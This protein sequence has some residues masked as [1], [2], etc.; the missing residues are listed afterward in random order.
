MSTVQQAVIERD[1]NARFLI[2]IISG[3][4]RADVFACLPRIVSLLKGTERER[5]TV[6]DV[7]MK[8]LTGTGGGSTGPTLPH[9]QPPGI[10]RRD[11][12][13]GPAAPMSGPQSQAQ[14][15]PGSSQARGPVMSPSEL[16]V[17]LH[18]MEDNVGWKAACEGKMECFSERNG[19]MF[20][21]RLLFVHCHSCPCFPL[22]FTTISHGHLLQPPRAL[23]V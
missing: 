7:F 15:Q 3:L 13:T 5:R 23:Q 1:L 14:G 11:S 12:S 19:P 16:L 21:P 4:E 22:A 6:T 20:F 17:E 18:A 2:P 10:T 8:L 9:S